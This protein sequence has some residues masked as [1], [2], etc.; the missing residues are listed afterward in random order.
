MPPFDGV[1]K[2][3]LSYITTMTPIGL[4]SDLNDTLTIDLLL[5]QAMVG[6]EA[7]IDVQALVANITAAPGPVF[8]A[9]DKLWPAVRASAGVRGVR[10]QLHFARV[11]KPT[12]PHHCHA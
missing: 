4:R 3:D 7:G 1:P 5:A 10:S 12:Q 8:Q 6:V 2:V 11:H 9:R